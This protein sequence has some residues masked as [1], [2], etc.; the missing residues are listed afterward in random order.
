[1]DIRTYRGVNTDPDHY[2]I[3]TMIR[4][5]ISYAMKLHGT[6]FKKYNHKR[7]KELEIG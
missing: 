3:T 6:Y 7:L 4:A 2:I 5:K 1:M